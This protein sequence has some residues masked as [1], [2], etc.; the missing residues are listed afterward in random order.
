MRESASRRPVPPADTRLP[1]P[2]ATNRPTG[3]PHEGTDVGAL[4]AQYASV[5]PLELDLTAFH[6][7]PLMEAWGWEQLLSQESAALLPAE[8][9]L[10]EP[11]AV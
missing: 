5:T 8:P 2:T 10:V 4:F 6:A 7:M 3:V 1:V 11:V 9:L